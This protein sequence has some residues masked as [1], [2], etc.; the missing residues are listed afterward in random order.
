MSMIEERFR[1]AELHLKSERVK[2]IPAYET[3]FMRLYGYAKQ[4]K[5]GDNKFPQPPA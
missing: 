2:A 1:E 3:H 4:A 5:E